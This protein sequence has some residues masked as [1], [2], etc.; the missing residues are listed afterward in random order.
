MALLLDTKVI[1]ESSS[2]M[3]V[4]GTHLIPGLS[5]SVYEIFQFFLFSTTK[6]IMVK[7]ALYSVCMI[8]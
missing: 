3:T 5:V 8:S 4:S 6:L 7:I 2:D 1:M